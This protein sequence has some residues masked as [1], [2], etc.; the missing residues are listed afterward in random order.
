MFFCCWC[1]IVGLQSNLTF[2]LPIIIK[3]GILY[4]KRKVNWDVSVGDFIV[5]IELCVWKQEMEH[6]SQ[7]EVGQVNKPLFTA[8]W[9]GCF[10]SL[11]M[12]VSL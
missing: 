2:W 5:L 9:M 10:V 12:F 8:Y 1:L 3:Y 7:E 11:P 4:S 6:E